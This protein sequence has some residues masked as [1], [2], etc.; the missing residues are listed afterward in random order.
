MPLHEIPG[1]KEALDKE[2][3][4]RDYALL[5][6][7]HDICGIAINPMR[8]RDFILL[9]AIRN[10]F[11]S[12]GYRRKVDA[13]QLI[14]LLSPDYEPMTGRLFHRLR[15]RLKRRKVMRAVARIAGLELIRAIDKFIDEMFMDAPG[16]NQNNEPSYVSFGA[17]II[18]AMH[19]RFSRDQLLD[20][21][22]PELWQHMRCMSDPR[23]PRFNKL[24]DRIKAD[25]ISQ[26]NGGKING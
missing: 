4:V 23:T 24:S 11:V 3:A 16:A 22:M 17:V 19:G 9:S 8:L 13:A 14:W 25:F 6:L 15:V 10:P 2:R 21:A 26:I 1:L 20:M 7:P 12:G 18:H 5:S